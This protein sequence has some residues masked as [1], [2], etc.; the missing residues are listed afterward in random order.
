MEF[1]FTRLAPAPGGHYSQAVIHGDL[2]FVSG[3]LPI[4]PGTGRM[5]EAGI[6][7]QVERV[8]D[9]VESILL[10]AGSRLDQVLKSSVFITDIAHW[11]AVNAVYA[12]RFGDHRPARAIIPCGPLHHGALLEMDVIAARLA[13]AAITD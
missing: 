11:P 10:A 4:D 6:E 2:V 3:Q 1:C 5:I 8:I 13:Q 9:H 7:A 12:R